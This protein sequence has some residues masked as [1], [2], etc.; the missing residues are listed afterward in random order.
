MSVQECCDIERRAYVVVVLL[1]RVLVVGV[2]VVA[3]ARV[4]VD[5]E[6]LRH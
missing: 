4:A 3:A 1:G 2:F 5:L 6:H